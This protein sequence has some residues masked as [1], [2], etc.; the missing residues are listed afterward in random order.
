MSSVTG[1]S[2]V[3]KCSNI[4]Q[5]TLTG[6][7]QEFKNIKLRHVTQHNDIQHFDT[8]HKELVCDAQQKDTHHNNALQ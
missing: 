7:R 4:L 1:S 5:N 2:L 8:Q 3:A 6:Q